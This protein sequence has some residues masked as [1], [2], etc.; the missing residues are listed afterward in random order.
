MKRLAALLF[1]ILCLAGC[2][3]AGTMQAPPPAHPPDLSG[4]FVQNVAQRLA[5]LPGDPFTHKSASATSKAGDPINLVFV[6]SSDQVRSALAQAGW[7]SADP[8]DLASSLNI[9][10]A[11]AFHRPYPTAPVSA[12]YEFGRAQ[13]LA[14]QRNSDDAISRDHCRLWRCPKSDAQG[15]EVWLVN[16]AKDADVRV[17]GGPTHVIA[18][19]LDAERDYLA[20]T[21][22]ATG[23]VSDDYRIAGIGHPYQGLN[24]EGDPYDTDG[25]A[26]VLDLSA[27][28][29]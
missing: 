9:A 24:G 25:M 18:P 20:A 12:L 27:H 11:V 6:G 28:G 29:S 1:S 17:L 15:H 13:D 4:L 7:V 21:L 19:T 16:A 2:G 8:I 5:A 3:Q 23:R 10:S 22:L 26:R 14:Y